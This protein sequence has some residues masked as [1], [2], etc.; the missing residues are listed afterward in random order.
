MGGRT[1]CS[2]SFSGCKYH[3]IRRP[4]ATVSVDDDNTILAERFHNIHRRRPIFDIAYVNLGHDDSVRSVYT[5]GAMS[6]D[7]K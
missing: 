6:E 7:P 3:L 5:G 1:A 2:Y 4:I